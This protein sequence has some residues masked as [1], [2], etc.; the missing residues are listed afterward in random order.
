MRT[1][2]DIKRDLDLWR[3]RLRW[4]MEDMSKADNKIDELK[5]E[6]AATEKGGE[7]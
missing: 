5:K 6:L 7:I 4:A 3:D 1:K 2:E